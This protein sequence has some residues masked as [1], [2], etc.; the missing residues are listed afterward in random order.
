MHKDVYIKLYLENLKKIV[1]DKDKF[2]DVL[3]T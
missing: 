3:L 2:I 1:A